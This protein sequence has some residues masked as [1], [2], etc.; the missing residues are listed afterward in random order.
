MRELDKSIL[1][2]VIPKKPLKKR[3]HGMG[4]FFLEKFSSSRFNSETERNIGTP[5][6]N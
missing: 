4:V 6:D 5:M 1:H 2:L 3:C